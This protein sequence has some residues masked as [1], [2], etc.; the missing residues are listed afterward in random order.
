MRKNLVGAGARELKYEIREI[1]EL[2]NQ[3]KSYGVDITRENIGDPVAKGEPIPEWM[4]KIV[5]EAC[6]HDSTYGYCPTKGL[7]SVREFIANRRKNLNKDDIIFFNGLGDAINKIYTN[8]AFDAR[9][10]GPN[11][12][13]STHSSAEANH[14]GSEHITYSL[15][16]KNGWNP[17]LEELENK[18]KF[19]PNIAGILVVNP[20]NPTGAV[21][22]KEVLKKI[23]DIARRYG[24]FVVFDEIYE[25][26]TYND[27]DRVILSDIIE[28]VPGIAMKGASKDLPW[29]GAR[30]GWIEVY[31]ADK[32]ANFR[33]YTKAILN[34]KMLEVCSTTL[35]QTVLP[36]IYASRDY[37]IYRLQRIEKYKTRAKLASEILGDLD[38]I[39]VVEPKGAFYLSVTFNT[40]KFPSSASLKIDNKE[41]KDFIEGKMSGIRFDKR[42]CY[43]LLASTGICSVPLSGF[44]STYNGFR[45]TLLEEN[46]DKYKGIL[47]TIREAIVEFSK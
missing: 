25:K 44:N 3:I 23:V 39:S 5:T 12:A 46:L 34:S 24:L 17:D 2:A 10:I 38:L 28:E 33:E 22:K 20:D 18:V 6:K 8:L 42:F 35:P 21:F 36:E 31:N 11:P 1:V 30:C 16:P 40:E 47:Q 43:Y 7:E 41:L 19:N 15:D 32:D 37:E 45:I 4:K 14:A 29:P 9:V 13:Y 27:E 26:L